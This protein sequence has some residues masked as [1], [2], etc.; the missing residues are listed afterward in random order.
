MLLSHFLGNDHADIFKS[1]GQIGTHSNSL[2][3]T[4]YLWVGSLNPLITLI[5][6]SNFDNPISPELEIACGFNPQS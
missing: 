2:N 5:S 6:G 4:D 1:L 3:K